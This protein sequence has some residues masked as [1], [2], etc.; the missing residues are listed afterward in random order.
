MD[1]EGQAKN[2]LELTEDEE[3]LIGQKI[4]Q[5]EKLVARSKVKKG[6]E[7]EVQYVG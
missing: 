3:K 6:H 2:F 5:V 1:R 4:G 7:Y